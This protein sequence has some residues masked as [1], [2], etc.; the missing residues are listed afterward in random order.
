MYS[1]CV[2]FVRT[3]FALNSVKT[4]PSSGVISFFFFFF[5]PR[6]FVRYYSVLRTVDSGQTICKAG[7]ITIELDF[8]YANIGPRVVRKTPLTIRET[9]CRRIYRVRLNILNKTSEPIKRF[10]SVVGSALGNY[11][12]F[13][14][15]TGR[16]STSQCIFRLHPSPSVNERFNYATTARTRVILNR[17]DRAMFSRRA[18]MS[19]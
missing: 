16:I 10:D 4:H 15:N 13:R 3:L 5:N 7:K 19:L 2:D 1:T 11:S 9:P 6:V 18:A 17:V 8:K 14:G 12:R